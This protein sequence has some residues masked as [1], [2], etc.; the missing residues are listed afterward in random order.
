MLLQPEGD[1]RVVPPLIDDPP[2][3][4]TNTLGNPIIWQDLLTTGADV[5]D[6][7]PAMRIVLSNQSIITSIYLSQR[8]LE[9][10]PLN[11]AG[12]PLL[13]TQA[14]S[15]YRLEQP[16]LSPTHLPPGV[17]MN[18]ILQ[19]RHQPIIAQLGLPIAPDPPLQSLQH[20]IVR[21]LLPDSMKDLLCLNQP[22]TIPF[23]DRSMPVMIALMNLL[24]IIYLAILLFSPVKTH[25]NLNCRHIPQVQPVINILVGMRLMNI[26]SMCR[27]LVGST[28][29]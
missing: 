4:I 28:D 23:Q 19:D 16:R 7:Q 11:P 13:F 6:R 25:H 5:H 21:A 3:P 15:P 2:L 17:G 24:P 1:S 18:N 27:T 29:P 22:N 20:T 10:R 9:N 8:L 26:I 14:G 12:L